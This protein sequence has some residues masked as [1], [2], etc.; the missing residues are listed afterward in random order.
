MEMEKV[1]AE[2]KNTVLMPK[3][4]ALL[5]LPLFLFPLGAPTLKLTLTPAVNSGLCKE[6]AKTTLLICNNLVL[7]PAVT[8]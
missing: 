8:F 1:F 4:S 7:L 3:P 2:F 6:N 5:L